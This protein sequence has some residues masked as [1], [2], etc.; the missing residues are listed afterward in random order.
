MNSEVDEVLKQTISRITNAVANFLPGLM[1][2][3]IIIPLAI[4]L[5]FILR[6]IVRRS[7]ERIRFDN[8]MDQWGFSAVAEFSPAQSPTQLIARA[9][10]LAILGIGILIG[11]SALDASLPSML[12]VKLFDYLP[13]VAAAILILFVGVVVAR[14]VARNVLISAVN[15]N[16][17]SAR[18]LS[19]GVK[20][21]VLVLTLAM[22]L[23]HLRIGGLVLQLSFGILLGGIVLALA[24]AIGLGSKEM[25]K[26]TWERQDDKT[27]RKAEEE[28][29]HHL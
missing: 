4:I 6:T 19:L 12:I 11:V 9:V 5:A 16:I 14:F 21:L 22:A 1:A 10:F 15:M 8:R 29:F 17:Q 7:L 26:Q 25:V 13:N 3:L 28:Q 23:D 27:E 2:L 24:L 18:M 20:W